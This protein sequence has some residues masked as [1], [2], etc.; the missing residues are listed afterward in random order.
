[1]WLRFNIVPNDLISVYDALAI[2]RQRGVNV[3]EWSQAIA[4]GAVPSWPS[5]E[6][7]LRVRRTDAEGWRPTTVDRSKLDELAAERN[8][9]DQR[10]YDEVLR[11]PADRASWF[12]IAEILGVTE[13][14]AQVAYEP[15][16][17]IGARMSAHF[18]TDLRAGGEPIRR[19]EP[20]PRTRNV[21]TE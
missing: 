16:P 18:V 5:A 13:R 17:G 14:E 10:I 7:Q 2:I 19:S 4:D 3:E 20:G 9:L 1:L 21:L 11:L 8:E 15:P 12:D 6:G